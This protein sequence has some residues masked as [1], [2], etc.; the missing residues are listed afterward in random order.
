M[1]TLLKKINRILNPTVRKSPTVQIKEN[2]YF[3]VPEQAKKSFKHFDRF[4]T[5]HYIK[6]INYLKSVQ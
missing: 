6:Y 3:Q 5:K 2:Q 1:K 4:N